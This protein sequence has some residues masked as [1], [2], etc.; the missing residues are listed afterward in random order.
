MAERKRGS[1]IDV[2]TLTELPFWYEPKVRS[3]DKT[4]Y[5]NQFVIGNRLASK[6]WIGQGENEIRLDIYLLDQE[7]MLTQLDNFRNLMLP[8]DDIGAPH[9]V[10][11]IVGGLYVGRWFVLEDMETDPEGFQYSDLMTPYEVQMRLKLCEIPVNQSFTG[12]GA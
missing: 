5:A 10:Y 9:P 11:I 4:G 6:Q 12:A 3:R 7:T 2:V 1:L 8:Q